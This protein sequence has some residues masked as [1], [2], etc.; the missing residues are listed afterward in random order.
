[1]KKIKRICV[2]LSCLILCSFALGCGKKEIPNSV[3]LNNEIYKTG[4]YGDLKPCSSQNGF[5]GDLYGKSTDVWNCPQVKAS[6]MEGYKVDYAEFS[7]LS[8]RHGMWQRVLY[9]QESE[10][11][12][13]KEYYSSFENFTYYIACGQNTEYD[14]VY[15]ISATEEYDGYFDLL[16]RANHKNARKNEEI[17]LTDRVFYV[18]KISKDGLLTSLREEYYLINDKLYLFSYLDGKDDSFYT[19][20]IEEEISNYFVNI[21]KGKINE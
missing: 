13:A 19:V 21:I 10:F 3:K 4:F 7:I 5:L 9:V 8:L 15:E 17:A 18:Y 16:L 12:R 6:G 14:K 1:M 11:L 2:I 20:E